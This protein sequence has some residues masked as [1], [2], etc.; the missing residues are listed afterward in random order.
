M[1]AAKHAPSARDRG[2]HTPG[3]ITRLGGTMDMVTGAN[4]LVRLAQK[5]Y[6][7]GFGRGEEF[8]AG[9]GAIIASGDGN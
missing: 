3:S 7:S 6:V 4:D 2:Q 1:N 8:H 5:F 9:K